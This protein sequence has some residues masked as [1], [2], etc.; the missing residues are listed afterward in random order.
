MPFKLDICPVVLV[1]VFGQPCYRGD[2]ACLND[3]KT[4]EVI[5]EKIERI[6]FLMLYLFLFLFVL[7]IMKKKYDYLIV[8]LVCMGAVFYSP[9]DGCQ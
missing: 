9:D 7:M 8:V 6:I 3:I 4:G 5:I 1:P 2:Y